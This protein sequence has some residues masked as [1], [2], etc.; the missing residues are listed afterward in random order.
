MVDE[1]D[2]ALKA[3]WWGLDVAWD[4]YIGTGTILFAL[5]MFGR[6]GLGAWFAVPGLLIGGLLLIFNIA[7][8]PKPPDTAGFVDLGPLVGLWYLVIYVRV[9][10]SAFL[11]E[12]QQRRVIASS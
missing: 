7:T 12:R 9:S 1:P 5:C 3:V 6:R 8:F 11:L 10:I 2:I 4:L